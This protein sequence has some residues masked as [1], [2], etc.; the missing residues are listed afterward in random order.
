MKRLLS[1]FIAAL[2]LMSAA[3]C[4]AVNQADS[5][6]LSSDDTVSLNAEEEAITIIAS[7]AAYIRSGSHQN[8]NFK[9]T[10]FYFI[11]NDGE[12]T[13]RHVIVKYDISS[14]T[15]PIGG[16]A[17]A[18]INFYSVSPIHPDNPATEI[19]LKAYKESSS[20]SS[21]T[22]TFSSLAP[23]S[24]SNYVAQNDLIKNDVY[25][26]ITPY[27]NEAI[28]NGEKYLTVRFVPSTRTVAEMRVNTLKSD[29]A[30]KLVIQKQAHSFYKYDILADEAANKEL[31]DYG[32]KTYDEW[33]A[34]YQ[35][36][37]A[38]GDYPTT[39]I[40]SNKSDYTIKTDAVSPDVLNKTL[41]FD[42]RLAT[43]L[44]GF[45]PSTEKAELD[46]YGGLIS[47]TRYEKTGYFYTKKV[48]GR[49]LVIDPLG[50]PC[51]ITGLNHVYYAYSQSKYQTKA[52]S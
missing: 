24:E 3:S 48:D 25:I 34:R 9:D 36:I 52:M 11:K 27:L 20:W 12:S 38:K 19:K 49:W 5:T 32:K 37:L 30:P 26:D 45:T 16:S 18:V 23:V 17:S 42:T 8:T 39:P 1:G 29:F 21:D 2:F 35:E 46:V 41:T 14:L 15:E 4:A 31:W 47:D 22:V 33:Y 51:Y 7:D 44:Q 6:I 43:T 13:T 40:N 10:E 28:A 50:Y